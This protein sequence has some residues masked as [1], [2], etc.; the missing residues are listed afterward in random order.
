MT[1]PN[2]APPRLC[3]PADPTA[4]KPTEAEISDAL[5]CAPSEDVLA[6][7]LRGILVR[8][9]EQ[10]KDIVAQDAARAVLA[11]FASQPTVAQVK[12]E[13]LQGV[14]YDTAFVRRCATDETYN[15]E[16]LSARDFGRWLAQV[17]AEAL[18]EAAD[19]MDDTDDP[20]AIHVYNGDIDLW[21]RARAER[22][23]SEG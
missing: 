2:S 4:V 9:F 6:D 15:G 18:R 10:D 13:A 3:T 19:D 20:D 5:R 17:K 1:M 22:I 12:A 8:V 14:T 21:L 23:E 16:L 11:L 7:V